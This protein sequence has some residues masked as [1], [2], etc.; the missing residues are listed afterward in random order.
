MAHTDLPPRPADSKGKKWVF[1]AP[2][3]WPTPP[4]D[5]RP[6]AGWR[7]DRSWPP[8]PAGWEFWKPASERP[9]REA[10]TYIKAIAGVVTFAATITGTYLA[11]LAIHD[12]PKV[13]TADW[14][15]KANATCDQDTGALSQSIFDGLTAAGQ[16]DTSGQSSS[17]GV[18]SGIVAAAGSMSKLVG[19]LGSLQSPVD[20]GAPKVQAVLTSGNDLVDNL[21]AFSNAAT[22]GQYEKS[23]GGSTAQEISTEHA[24]Y[25]KFLV[26][27]V[28]W[29]KAIGALG[30]VQCPFWVANPDA[31]LPT[32]QPV[33]SHPVQSPVSSLNG[34]EQQLVSVL[35]PGDLTNCT[36][37]PDMEGNG[38]VAAVDCQTVDAGPAQQPLIV[39]FSNV[40]TAAA[41]FRYYTSGF[42]NDSDCAAGNMVGTWD[43][44]Y[45][46]AGVLGCSNLSDGGFRIVWVIAN[47]LIG[48]I[49]DGTNGQVMYSW[50]TNS[51]YVVS[52][53]G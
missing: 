49:A 19:D 15:R 30:L 13:T 14:V 11:Y 46:T 27:V 7:P 44:D 20:G 43:H 10:K 39:Q 52:G 42:V 9:K 51:A 4:A 25:K 31:P 38:I 8:A 36:G 22:E 40:E 16:A 41:W 45:V 5:W 47:P 23:L 34:G 1:N 12:Q 2:P 17:E 21:D 35:N 53:G 18:A 29:R 3:G 37:R 24:A 26:N 28:V 50:W 33:V 32:P 48:I 6:E